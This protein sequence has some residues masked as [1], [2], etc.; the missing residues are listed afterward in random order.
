[1]PRRRLLALAGGVMGM[2]LAAACAPGSPQ[3]SSGA[4]APTSSAAATGAPGRPATAAV[5][6]DASGQPRSGGALQIGTI[7]DITQLEGHRLQGQNWNML[8]PIFDRL[9][10]YDDTLVP[11]PKL[12]ESWDFATDNRT[13]QIHLR[14]GVQFHTGRELTSDDVKFNILRAR[15][16]KTGAAQMVTM[17]NWWSDIQTPDKNTVVLVSDQPRPAA[18]DFL[19]YLNIVDPVTAQSP[20]AATTLVG[21]GPFSLGEWVTGDHLTLKKNPQY[22]HSGAPYLDEITFHIGRDQQ[23]LITQLEAGAI[24]AMD[25][26]PITDAVRLKADPAYSL[27][28][29]ANTGGYNAV[30]ANTSVAPLDN[31][32]VRQALN[33]AINRQRYVDSVLHG[34]GVAEDLVWPSGSP[35]YEP[36]KNT[37]YAFDLEHAKQLLT[38]AGIG[39]FA[40]ELTYVSANASFGQLAQIYQSDLASIGVTATLKPVDSAVWGQIT[41]KAQYN[42]LNIAPGGFAQVQPTTF[43][44]FSVYWL[45]QNNAEAFESDQ[46]RQLLTAAGSE[47]EPAKRKQLLSDLNDFVLDQSF[48]M[49]ISSNPETFLTRANVHG[50]S[51]NMHQGLQM[52]QLWKS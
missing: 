23:A 44:L 8:Y 25:A 18:F 37:Q 40:L 5:G 51:Y 19:E 30:L 50:Q 14:P 17:G 4:E 43:F 52:Q 32:Q 41:P 10:E 13:L 24:D 11:Q 21:T 9:T 45:L 42:G 7:T 12:A 16:P 38:A 20:N 3:A 1:M 2:G 22:W 31:K 34:V 28:V 6:G 15:D 49:L 47:T 39:P 35:A 48:V 33:Y 26:P 36:A 27:M 29:N 46:Y